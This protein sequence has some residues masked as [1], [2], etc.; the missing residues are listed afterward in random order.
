MR[1]VDR[2]APPRLAV[3]SRAGELK[4]TAAVQAGVIPEEDPL[5]RLVAEKEAEE[6][7]RL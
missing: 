1:G 7:A 2:V 4:G 3:S 5:A 6:R